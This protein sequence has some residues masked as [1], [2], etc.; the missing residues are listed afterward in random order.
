M[1]P[2]LS[3]LLLDVRAH[4]SDLQ[5]DSFI[6]LRSGGTLF[7][8]YHQ[9]LREI[10]TRV[11][12]LHSIYHNRASLL[13]DI[14]R[15]EEKSQGDDF[16]ARKAAVKLANAR[17]LF[18]SNERERLEMEGEFIRFYGQAIAIREALADQGVTFPLDAETRYSLDCEMWEHRLKGMAAV[19]FMTTG[20]LGRNVIEFIQAAPADMRS[21]LAADVLNADRHNELVDWFLAYEP[22]IPAPAMLSPEEIKGLLP[23]EFSPSFERVGSSSR[24]A[25]R[26]RLEPSIASG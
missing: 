16:K 11:S 2:A 6:T 15:Y 3:E 20:R 19:D 13:V 24:M 26:R 10:N 22:E 21:R 9:A 1:V 14:E 7:G 18:D 25:A 5:M 8:C 12:A 23:C 17:F 4:H